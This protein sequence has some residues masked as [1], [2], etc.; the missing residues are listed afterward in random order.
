MGLFKK[1]LPVEL[2]VIGMLKD[3]MPFA[4]RKYQ[5]E[6]E[7]LRHQV[8]L[9]EATFPNIF[10]AMAMFYLSGKFRS[11]SARNTDIMQRAF[12][13]MWQYLPQFGGN[14]EKANQWFQIFNDQ[15]LATQDK[16]RVKMVAH[17][18]SEQLGLP[19]P[20]AGDSALWF[21]AFIVHSGLNTIDNF[22]LT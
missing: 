21:L 9:S 15:L 14:T 4:M 6:N 19:A 10:A 8:N 16:D 5:E 11:P 13:A 12:Q 2:A 22:K 20:V 1:R 3:A 17:A 7:Q 18:M